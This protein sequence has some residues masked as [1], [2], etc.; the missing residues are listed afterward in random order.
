[1][2]GAVPY[3]STL[4]LTNVT[5]PYVMRIANN[6]W[7]NALKADPGLEKGLNINNGEIVLDELKG[8]F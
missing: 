4:A 6:G 3:T 5:F 8:I 2:P 7:E 1:M